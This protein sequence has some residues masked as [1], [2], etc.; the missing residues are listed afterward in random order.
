GQRASLEGPPGS[1]VPVHVRVAIRAMALAVLLLP[2]AA[3]QPTQTVLS[4]ALEGPAP[5]DAI[6]TTYRPPSTP[7]YDV[8]RDSVFA[9]EQRRYGSLTCVYTGFSVVLSPGADPSTDAYNR[10]INTEHTWPQSMGA[11]AEPS[12]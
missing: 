1:T 3:A 12:R 2:A 9:W 10:G 6:R 11:S 5:P 4:P 8:A 7:G